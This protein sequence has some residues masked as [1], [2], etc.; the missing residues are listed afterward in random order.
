MSLT[1]ARFMWRSNLSRGT[2]FLCRD[3]MMLFVNVVIIK[4]CA[5]LRF[6]S[7]FSSLVRFAMF[8]CNFALLSTSDL[9]ST[10]VRFAMFGCNFARLNRTELNFSTLYSTELHLDISP[11]RSTS[12]YKTLQHFTLLCLDITLLCY[13][14]QNTTALRCTTLDFTTQ[15]KTPIEYN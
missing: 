8:G 7:L 9:R 11:V 5:V 10:L 4:N 12:L 3:F 15:D 2:N 14:S 1:F 6:S 13:S